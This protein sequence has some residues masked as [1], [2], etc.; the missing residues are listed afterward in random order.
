[1]EDRIVFGIDFELNKAGKA[2]KAV[3]DFYAT[4]AERVKKYSQ[5]A[6]KANKE[7]G[8]A[9]RK[10]GV[11]STAEVK[12]KINELT[13]AYKQLER[14]G[15]VS[16]RDLARA[17]A[18]LKRK[19]SELNA[20]LKSGTGVMRQL[21]S[22][23]LSVLAAMYALNRAF[24]EYLAFSKKMTEVNTLLSITRTDTNSCPVM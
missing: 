2:Q 16:A 3:R 10:L 8:E 13:Q 1:L 4:S 15:T 5:T 12:R 6:V 19:T 21:R 7:V 11:S 24:A 14:S 20:E 23:W 22:H 9:F 18:E 17:Q